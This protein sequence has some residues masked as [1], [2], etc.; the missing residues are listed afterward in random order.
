MKEVVAA[1]AK[2]VG[3]APKAKKAEAHP[4]LPT[5]DKPLRCKWCG[6]TDFSSVQSLGGHSGWCR[7]AHMRATVPA[8]K[9]QAE[10]VE[11]AT[12][13]VEKKAK[14]KSRK[15]GEQRVYLDGDELKRLRGARN[16]SQRDIANL[17][18][19][20]N[21]TYGHI[22]LGHR[23][24]IMSTAQRLAGVLGVTVHDFTATPE[25]KKAPKREL[26]AID[27]EMLRLAREE[28]ALSRKELAQKVGVSSQWIDMLERGEFP[29]TN[30]I[31]LDRIST[32]LGVEPSILIDNRANH[33]NGS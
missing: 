28:V 12:P 2:V 3:P 23:P 13:V 18:D 10:K 27:G 24:M 19:L 16:L 5:S 29:R 30:S 32:T 33:T 31:I 11:P 25:S 22:E 26:V 17:I 21:S 6:R 8:P 9:A 14:P 7:K 4:R 1:V 20:K 15:L